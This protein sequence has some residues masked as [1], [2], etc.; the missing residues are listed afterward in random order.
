MCSEGE[1][2][3]RKKTKHTAM[4]LGLVTP[5]PRPTAEQEARYALNLAACI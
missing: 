3:N 1:I 2:K 4:R 5:K